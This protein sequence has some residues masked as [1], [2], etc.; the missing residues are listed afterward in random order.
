[1]TAPG[2]D[3][4]KT[5]LRLQ[6][7]RD[8]SHIKM[9]LITAPA[10]NANQTKRQHVTPDAYLTTPFDPG[11][12]IRVIASLQHSKSKELLRYSITDHLKPV[13]RDQAISGSRRTLRMD[14]RPSAFQ[15]L[16]HPES[17]YRERR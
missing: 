3:G 9:V 15:E 10:Q 1:V 7:Y 11:E 12:M 16:C 5:A 14:L 17:S 6:K 13:N 4:W 8:T 2:T